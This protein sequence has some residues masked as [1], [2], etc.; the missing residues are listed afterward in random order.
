LQTITYE[1][2]LADW[3]RV[4]VGEDAFKNVQAKEIVCKDGTIP[5]N[6]A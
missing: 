6:V 3:K 2:T 4:L 5:I 1:G